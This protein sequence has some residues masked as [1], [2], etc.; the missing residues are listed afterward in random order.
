[1]STPTTPNLNLYLPNFND[2]PW[3][4]EINDNFRSIDATIK[5]IFGIEGLLGEYK[6]ST[7]VTSGQRYFDVTAGFY[8]E[9]QSDF[10]TLASPNTF[11]QERTAHPTR[12][13]QLDASAAIASAQNAANSAAA[14]LASQNAASTSA[15]NA[16]TSETNA[17]NS[18]TA[19]A[20]SET[21]AAGSATAAANSAT[22]AATFNPA[23]YVAKTGD[24]MTGSLSVRQY[25][26][27]GLSGLVT[28]NESNAGYL[29]IVNI[30]GTRK[31][32]LGWGSKT[33]YLNL[34]TENGSPGIH[35]NTDVKISNLPCFYAIAGIDDIAD[36][37]YRRLLFSRRVQTN[38]G[39]HF[40]SSTGRFTA[41][42]AG[43]YYFSAAIMGSTTY[44]WWRFRKNGFIISDY[45]HT[46]DVSGT[47]YNHSSG[48]MIL[49]LAQG[50]YIDVLSRTIYDNASDWHS[51]CGFKI[52]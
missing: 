6:N 25:T 5:S 33:S 50:D 21:N 4:D 22:Q 45:H 27:D 24:V 32:Y 9:A 17:A 48:S 44:N 12:W 18:A 42:I 13:E 8:Y 2:S 49:S 28:G 19:A 39:S 51:F 38:N 7:A 37:S 34:F 26:G 1:M 40:N 43:L 52:G 29:Q 3:H 10:T 16:A 20:T 35:F 15:T 36:G 31:A 30:D 23:N 11:A 47:G 46:A 41:P 14:A